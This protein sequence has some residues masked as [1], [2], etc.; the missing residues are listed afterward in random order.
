MIDEPEKQLKA[1]ESWERYSRDLLHAYQE[2]H[3]V[4]VDA[5]R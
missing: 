5:H 3:V 1:L 4:A 2:G